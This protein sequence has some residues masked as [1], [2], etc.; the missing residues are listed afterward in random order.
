M[1][2]DN[3]TA[4]NRANA[5]KSTGPKTRAGKA[6]VAGN[7]RRHGATGRPAPESVATWLRIILDQPDITPGNLLPPNERGMRALALAETEATLYGCAEALRSFEETASPPGQ[8]PKDLQK[9]LGHILKDLQ[10]RRASEK[11][12][13]TTIH[14]VQPLVRDEKDTASIGGKRYILLKRYLREARARRNR[15]FHEW[16][17]VAAMDDRAAA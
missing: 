10:G 4:R 6:V 3:I 7:A 16:C 9:M 12:I 11:E 17:T 1:T 15:A 5:R 14:A 8:V 13:L 2:P